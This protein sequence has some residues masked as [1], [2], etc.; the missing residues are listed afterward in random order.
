ME[1]TERRKHWEAVYQT[2]ASDAVS[3][4]QPEPT[5]SLDLLHRAGLTRESCVIDVGGG[6]SRLVDNL[7]GEGLTCLAVL[8]VSE[9]ALNRAKARLGGK[10]PLVEWVAADVTAS[11]SVSPRDFWHDRAGFHFLTLASDRARYIERLRQTLKP[12]GK[13]LIATFAPD[14]PEKCSGLSVTRYSPDA[15]ATELGSDF[16]LV[17]HMADIHRTPWGTTQ[18]FIYCVFAFTVSTQRR[19]AAER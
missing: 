1:S 16:T 7:I 9:A 12:G 19:K 17:E 4:F 3:W 6:D 13:A 8:D 2:K 18:S 5:Q 14:G 11:W 10:A 15:L